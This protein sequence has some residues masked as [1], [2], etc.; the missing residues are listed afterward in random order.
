ML[1]EYLSQMAPD[2]LLISNPLKNY[3]ERLQNNNILLA[4]FDQVFLSNVENI[5]FLNENDDI[6]QPFDDFTNKC[7]LIVFWRQFTLSMVHLNKPTA[8]YFSIW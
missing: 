7:L 1:K 8:S 5:F 4:W 2:L 3:F 6:H